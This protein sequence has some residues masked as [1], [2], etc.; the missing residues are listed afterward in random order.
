MILRVTRTFNYDK[1]QSFGALYRKRIIAVTLDG[2][3]YCEA[4]FH[5]SPSPANVRYAYF[6]AGWTG[7]IQVKFLAQGHNKRHHQYLGIKSGP[8]RS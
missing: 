6:T 2:Y 3:V 7:A 1:V 8:F 4:G 5:T